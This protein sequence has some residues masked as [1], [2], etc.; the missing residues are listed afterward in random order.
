MH[1]H[2]HP[3]LT[4]IKVC[5]IVK[6]LGIVFVSSRNAPPEDVHVNILLLNENAHGRLYL[7]SSSSTDE[8]NSSCMK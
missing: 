5:E 3:F 6:D 1:L 2:H 7:R 8:D 4:W